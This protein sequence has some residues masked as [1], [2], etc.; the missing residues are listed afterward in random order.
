MYVRC[1]TFQSWQPFSVLGYLRL[2]FVYCKD[3]SSRQV[4]VVDTNNLWPN[5]PKYNEYLSP[6]TCA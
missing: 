6:V 5:S 2:Y 1:A 4:A 3:L